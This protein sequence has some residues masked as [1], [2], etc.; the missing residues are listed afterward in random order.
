[1]VPLKLVPFVDVTDARNA[2]NA[3]DLKTRFR[4]APTL[5]EKPATWELVD[6]DDLWRPFIFAIDLWLE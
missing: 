6:I 5:A 1:M 2:C 4:S 3:P